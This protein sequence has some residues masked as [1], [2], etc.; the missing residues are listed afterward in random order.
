MTNW[1]SYTEYI[2]NA[3]NSG[4]DVHA[5]YTDFSKAFD[6]VNYDILIL[7]LHQYCVMGKALEWLISHLTG[8]KLQ[9]KIVRHLSKE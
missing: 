4:L 7:E 9:V 6:T 8:R 3:F 1:G 5:I 2:F